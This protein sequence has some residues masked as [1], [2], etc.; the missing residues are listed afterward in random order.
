MTVSVS[1]VIPV[2]NGAAFIASTINSVL[3]QTYKDYEI[4][5][6]NDGSKDDTLIELNKFENLISVIN[7]PN[8]GVSNARNI[9]ILA[10]KGEMIAF[11]DADDQW[12]PKK[13]ELQLAVMNSNS[14]IGFCCCN[15]VSLDRFSGV[16]TYHFDQFKNDLEIVL[17]KV[18]TPSVV[19]K[20]ITKGNFIGTASNVIVRRDVLEKTG[21]FDTRFKQAEDLDLYIRCAME[22]QFFLMSEALLE[23]KSHENNL[24]NNLIETFLC[25]ETV[26]ATL[27]QS[28]MVKTSPQLKK[29]IRRGVAGARYLIGN[30]YFHRGEFRKC[31]HH[32]GAAGK[33]DLSL[34]N[35]TNFVIQS[36]KKIGLLILQKTGLRNPRQRIF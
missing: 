6:V 8:G 5:V 26:L 1:V 29:S 19:E 24:T 33:A 11:L 31:V 28:E 10:S 13:L 23:K 35:A 12:Y 25:H 7:I 21:L 30:E 16:A 18:M 15:Y 17:D 4:I 2:Y 3:C 32:F 22:T 20:L 27:M 36:I 9:G 14:A 34:E